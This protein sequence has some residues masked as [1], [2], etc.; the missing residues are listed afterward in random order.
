VFKDVNVKRGLRPPRQLRDQKQSLFAVYDVR[1][2]DAD[3]DA[4]LRVLV[5]C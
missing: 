5:P 4:E 2:I 1:L 3:V